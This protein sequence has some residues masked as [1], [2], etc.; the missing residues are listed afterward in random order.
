MPTPFARP[1]LAHAVLLALGVSPAFAQPAP[2]TRLDPVIITVDPLARDE[3]QI[4]RPVSVLRG[5]ALRDKEGTNLG[6]TLGREPGVQSSSYG[7]GAGRPIIRGM[8]SAR[9]RVT[10]SGLGVAD[11]SGAS[12]DHRVSADTLL[13]PQVEIL[14]GPATLLYGSG[15]IGG[16][17][18]VV[19]ERVPFDRLDKAGGQFNLRGST[20][21]RERAAA[22]AL[23]GPVTRDGAWRLEGFKQRTDAYALAAPLRDDTGAVI[24]D[25][26]L[27]NSQ[28]DTQSVALG[29]AW[30]GATAGTRLGAA[31]QRYESDYGIPNPEEPVTIRLRRTRTELNADAGQ[32]LGPLAGLKTKLA[33]TDYT[34]TEFEPTGEPGATFTSK[35]T[36]A[37]AEWPWGTREAWR[38]VLGVQLT[39]MQT[40]GAGEGELP[41]TAHRGAALFAVQERAFGALTAEL[42]ARVDSDRYRV[43]ED[44][45]AGN[46]APS[47]SFALT[48]VSAGASWALAPGWSLGG[49]LTSAE[50]AP[51]VEELYFVGAHPATFAYEVGDPDLKKERST[52]LD[53]SLRFAQPRLRAQASVFVNRVRNYIYGFFDG[54]GTDILDENGNVEETLSNL[55]FAQADAR[56]H[57]GEAHVIMGDRTGAQAR[58]WGDTVRARLTS[59]PARDNNLPRTSPGRLGLDLGWR[60]ADWTT[61]VA[62]TRVMKQA[63]VAAFDLRNGE[64]ESTTAGYTV[65]DAT[66]TLRVALAGLP[67]KLYVQGRNLTDQDIRIHTSFLKDIAPPPGRS[68]WVGVRGSF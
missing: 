30:F 9:V 8:D 55:F 49:T 43:Q 53:L 31:V 40:R 33:V 23:D 46:R 36:E 28:T 56:L 14:R 60:E 20:A 41:K 68:L 54:S 37:R 47:R 24:A 61:Q 1:V 21:E 48:T 17:V 18:N 39:Q 26:R 19:S 58:L 15:A 29:G 63:R 22:L 27:P 45:A 38:G 65:L 42:G 4:Q 16:L 52:N 6:D 34:H 67:L 57:G 44:Y 3:L 5:D 64:A 10:E 7:P 51:A 12:P 2:A 32:A 59:G 62:V 66:A 25:K 13:A 50:R 11:V 35:G